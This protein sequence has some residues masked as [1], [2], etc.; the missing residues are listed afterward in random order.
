[1][2][3]LRHTEAELKKTLLIKKNTCIGKKLFKL[4]NRHFP[5]HK[6]P[7]IFNR[8]ALKVSYSYYCRDI[9]LVTASHKREI[10]QPTCK[11][12]GCNCRNMAKCPL[13]SKFLN[14]LNIFVGD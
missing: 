11:N 4:I 9:D 8:N 6:M 12:Q 5:K 10:I 2:K 1:M 13:D 3:K 7:K 14:F